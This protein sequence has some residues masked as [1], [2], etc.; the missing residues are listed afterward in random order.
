MSTID[1]KLAE[2]LGH[3]VLENIKLQA[4]IEELRKK[5]SA[6]QIADYASGAAAPQDGDGS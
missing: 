6:Y 3:L 1:R 5:L 4:L 2:H